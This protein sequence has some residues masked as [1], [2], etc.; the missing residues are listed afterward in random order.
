MQNAKEIQYFLSL[1]YSS[2]KKTLCLYIKVQGLIA[3]HLKTTL[4]EKMF[5]M[6]SKTSQNVK[7]LKQGL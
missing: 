6:S 2:Q 1:I 5:V 7:I 4:S 3:L